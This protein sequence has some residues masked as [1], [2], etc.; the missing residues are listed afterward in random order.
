MIGAERLEQ[1]RRAD[2][3]GRN[4]SVKEE[5]LAETLAE[6]SKLCPD[7]AARSLHSP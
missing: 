7:A 5:T 2:R 3:Q 4:G 1:L 6:Q